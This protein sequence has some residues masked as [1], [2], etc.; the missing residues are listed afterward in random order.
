MS[1]IEIQERCQER[2]PEGKAVSN[3]FYI[4]GKTNNNEE[5]TSSV[6]ITPTPDSEVNSQSN[7]SNLKNQKTDYPLL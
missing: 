1:S 6:S 4:H 2:S 5:C 7:N 3:I